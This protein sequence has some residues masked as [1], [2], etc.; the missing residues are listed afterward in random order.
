MAY[1]F[2]GDSLLVGRKIRLKAG[3]GSDANYLNSSKWSGYFSID[4]EQEFSL[5]LP[6]VVP[7][8][9][10][11]STTVNV[12]RIRVKIYSVGASM[13]IKLARDD[14]PMLMI[15]NTSSFSFKIFQYGGGANV[16]V[17]GFQTASFAWE[18]PD[19]PRKIACMMVE[20]KSESKYESRGT[21]RFCD[22]DSLDREETIVWDVHGQVV[23]GEVKFKNASRVLAFRH[24]N[25]A[26][27]VQTKFR[28]DV[29]VL[30]VRRAIE[31]AKEDKRQGYMKLTTDTKSDQIHEIG[32]KGIN[33]SGI[34][35]FESKSTIMCVKRPRELRVDL[36]ED[37][38]VENQEEIPLPPL[39]IVDFSDPSVSLTPQEAQSPTASFHKLTDDE[40]K[41][42]IESRLPQYPPLLR[43]TTGLHQE[44]VDE[45]SVGCP[46][47]PLDDGMYQVIVPKGKNIGSVDIK[48]PKKV[49]KQFQQGTERSLSDQQGYWWNMMTDDGQVVG[50]VQLS[51]KFGMSTMKDQEHSHR[52]ERQQPPCLNAFQM[53]IRLSSLAISFVH[54]TYRLDVAYLSMQRI[55][56]MYSDLGGSSEV[57]LAIGNLQMD[58]Q[59]DRKVVLGPRGVKRKEGVS[60]RLRDRWKS[61][62]NHQYRG[63]YEQVDVQALPVVQFRMLYN[64]QCS[65]GAFH[66]ELVELI[67]Q[68]IEIT[69]D[70]KFVVSLINVF[71]GIESLSSSETFASVVDQR[72]IYSEPFKNDASPNESTQITDGIYIEQLDIESIRILFSLELNGGKHIATLGPSGRRLAMYLPVSN[73]KDMRLNFSKLFFAHIFESKEIILDKLYR[74][75]HQQALYIVLQGLYTVSL[76]VNPFRIVYRLGHGFLE[77]VRLPTRG[78]ASGS[79]IELVSGAYLGVRSLAMNTISASYETFAGAT[80]VLAAVIAPMIVNEE[81]KN[82]FMEEMVNFQRAV[83]GEV[84]AF[85]AAEERHMSK[86]IMRAP[87]VFAGI[88]LLVE[89][90]PGAL[91]KED[92]MRVDLQAAVLVQKWWRRHRLCLAL[93]HHAAMLKEAKGPDAMYEANGSRTEC[94]IL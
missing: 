67:M 72:V 89:Y 79:P 65:A 41:G 14:P 26:E 10:D 20:R 50:Q 42:P 86:Y 1:D 63:I 94:V 87:R 70:E 56:A 77:V 64:D 55:H 59:I 36:I 80:G 69:T 43:N 11:T 90:G 27:F 23:V 49:W 16:I 78:L 88:G 51:L 32:P 68:E 82:K 54:N 13:V 39:E 92:Q 75:Y 81:K 33:Q 17:D 47:N 73:V 6:D 74:H 91:P 83:M 93:F 85:D 45:L 19:Q 29:H 76:F 5:W 34:Y 9:P 62:L 8:W 30:A 15:D 21:I 7:L 18:Q 22:F 48:L 46:V 31:V 3:G 60:V 4:E 37:T 40:S 53:S 24:V 38:R 25:K 71:G 61:C 2:P 84:E 35:R 52:D 57:A 58:N 44:Y 12:P 66:V 28:L